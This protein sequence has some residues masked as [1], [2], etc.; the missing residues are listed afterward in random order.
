MDGLK[1]GAAFEWSRAITAEDIRRFAELSGDAGRHHV[2]P[3]ESGRLVAHG[4]MTA[5]LPTKLGGDLNFM[6]REMHF[7]FL[8]Q[9]FSGDELLCRGVIDSV[10]TR[11]SHHKVKFIFTITNQSGETVL[12]GTSAGIISRKK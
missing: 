10:V 5:S 1:A 2:E 6:A 9:V 4:L 3:D 7:E 8:R 11:P 12:K